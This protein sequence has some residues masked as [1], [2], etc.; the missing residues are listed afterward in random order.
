[1]ELSINLGYE[2]ILQLVKGLPYSQKE[3]LTREIERDLKTKKRKETNDGESLNDLQ[4]LLLYGPLMS[5]EQYNDFKV[6]RKDF[7]KWIE[8]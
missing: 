2:Q 1:M 5:D 3:K 8:K 4:Q 7:A 6:L